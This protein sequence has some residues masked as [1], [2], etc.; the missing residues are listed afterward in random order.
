L[1]WK[2]NRTKQSLT[3]G[4]SLGVIKEDRHKQMSKQD[5]KYNEDVLLLAADEL[6]GER[7]KDAEKAIAASP[8]SQQQ[9]RLIRI[10]LALPRR[11]APVRPRRSTLDALRA[12]ARASMPR[13]SL[14]DRL[15]G[16]FQTRQVRLAAVAAVVLLAVGLYLP[17]VLNPGPPPIDFAAIEYD[18]ISSI[19]S[20]QLALGSMEEFPTVDEIAA[21]SAVDTLWTSGPSDVEETFESLHESLDLLDLELDAV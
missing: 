20:A 5:N 19:D 6:T 7:Q 2:R 10:L 15:A 3:S 21:Q 9:Y 17:K 8:E 16:L 12:E 13:R 1:N 18:I 4:L 14:L 11:L